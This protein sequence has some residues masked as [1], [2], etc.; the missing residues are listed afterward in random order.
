[1]SQ[2]LSASEATA[3]IRSST[4]TSVD[5]V[6]RCIARI[7]ALEDTVRAWT[8]FDPAYALHQAQ[9]ADRL[10]RANAPLAPLHGVP[11]GIKG[12]F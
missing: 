11:V 3:A 5:L 7:D 4:L 8:F 2:T 9:E 1:V 10:H 6:Q 12:H